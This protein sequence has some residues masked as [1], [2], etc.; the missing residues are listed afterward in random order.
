MPGGRPV[1][2]TGT[3]AHRRAAARIEKDFPEYQPVAE[4]A[5]IALA[6]SE[7]A[8]PY[9]EAAPELL[10]ECQAAHDKVAA[11]LV[12][13]LRSVEVTGAGG[14]AIVVQTAVASDAE[15]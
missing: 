11:Y 14:G 9:A 4:M 15:L 6:L 5:A 10:R 8:K 13:K 2:T 12:P 7:K 3:P 1:G